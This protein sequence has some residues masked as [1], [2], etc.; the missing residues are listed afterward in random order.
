MQTE[1]K[2]PMPKQ[3]HPKP[4]IESEVTPRPRY[5]AP[6]YKAAGKLQGKTALITGGDSGIGR[7]VAVLYAREGADVAISYLPEEQ[8]DAEETAFKAPI[9]EQYSRQG[10]A[11]YATARLWDDGVIDPLETR[12]VLTLG[13]SAAMNAPI[14]KTTFG[15]FRM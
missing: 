8:S 1:P 9:L 10:S 4:G 14:E 3:H 7:A 11:Y 15:V 5:Q 13:L 6:K 2:S 12:K